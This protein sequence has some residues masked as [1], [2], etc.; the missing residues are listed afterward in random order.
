L[1][2]AVMGGIYLGIFTAS[3]A[4][5]VGAFGA[6]LITLARRRLGWK[7][8]YEILVETARMTSTL[9]LILFGALLFS[10]FVNIAGLPSDLQRWILALGANQTAVL[11]AIVVMYFLLGMVIESISMMLLTV[12]IFY[13]LVVGL[14]VDPIWFGVFVVMAIEISLITPPVGLNV[15]VLKTVITDVP[16]TTVFRGVAPFVAMD[17]VRILLLIGVPWLALVIPSTM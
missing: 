11:L 8:L 14:G 1:F 13:P 17:V 10:N 6:L 5:G 7:M 12:P 3:E 4:A 15:F 9:F 2:V 16:S